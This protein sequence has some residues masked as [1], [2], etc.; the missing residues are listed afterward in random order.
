[1][2]LI[3]IVR[4]VTPFAAMLCVLLATAISAQT[5]KPQFEVASV[6][7]NLSNDK[8]TSSFSLDNGFTFSTIGKG[9]T[10]VPPGGLFSATNLS[11]LSYISF[12]Y[13]LT[14]TQF[15][16]IRAWQL[17][18][19]DFVGSSTTLP[20]W[21]YGDR[22]DIRARAPEGSTRDDMRLLLQA[23]LA[24][25][26][27]LVVHHEQRQVPIYAMVPI[28][29]GQTGPG[30][31]PHPAE[32]TCASDSPARGYPADCGVIAH[33]ATSAPGRLSFGGRAV[34][35]D[36]LANAMPTQTGMATLSRPVVDETGLAGAYDFILEW[37]PP[38]QEG[39]QQD[40][41]GPVFQQALKEQLGLRLES[42]KGPVDVL[43]ID[44]IEHPSGN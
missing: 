6:R 3:R 26:F 21:F 24:E 44:R 40:S 10:L 29:P 28:R 27:G 25:R 33:L 34:T 22:F 15:L 8:P 14:G 38:A 31:R 2:P 32:D 37:V 30:L 35:L 19:N 7:Q 1:M 36:L 4:R 17:G 16:A 42:K 20:K 11:L 43:V 13:K 23:L 12:A 5:A 41:S 39:A 9:D 18:F